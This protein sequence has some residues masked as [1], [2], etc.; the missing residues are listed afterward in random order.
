MKCQH[1]PVAVSCDWQM[2]V[3][4]LVDDGETIGR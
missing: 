4:L 1:L 3:K 2:M